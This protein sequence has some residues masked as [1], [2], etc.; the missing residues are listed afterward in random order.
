M[1]YSFD[2]IQN[3]VLLISFLDS[4]LLLW[5]QVDLGALI[6]VFYYLLNFFVSCSSF[7]PDSLVFSTYRIISPADKDSFTSSFPI[8]FRNYYYYIYC[9]EL[10]EHCRVKV[11]GI[12]ILVLFPSGESIGTFTIKH[13][14]SCRFL[15]CRFP[16]LG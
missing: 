12:G 2:A 3:G 1:F 16:L 4:L 13:G 11:V 9:L 14:S 6:L 10:P 5:K 8:S 7:N 15:F